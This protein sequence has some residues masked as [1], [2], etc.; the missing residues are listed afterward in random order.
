MRPTQKK[1]IERQIK[2]WEDRVW[3]PEVT[4]EK[5]VNEDGE[6]VLVE[7]PEFN[8]IFEDSKFECLYSEN[9]ENLYR[10]MRYGIE[11]GKVYNSNII[12]SRKSIFETFVIPEG[13]LKESYNL[14]KEMMNSISPNFQ[15]K[16]LICDSL[17]CD[18]NDK[19]AVYFIT[20]LK[21]SKALGLVFSCNSKL[22]NNLLSCIETSG[23]I[24][25][26]KI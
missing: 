12:F 16:W 25:V 19:L 18:F 23:A 7:K 11:K 22:P 8:K 14:I 15:G 24:D 10:F 9:K 13:N 26:K 3:L 5:E 2:I 17:D 6:L 21:M 1:I 20:Q 4:P